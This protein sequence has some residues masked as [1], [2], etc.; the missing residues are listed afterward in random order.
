[1]AGFLGFS[2]IVFAQDNQPNPASNKGTQTMCPVMNEPIDKDLYVDYDGKRIYVCCYGCLDTVKADPAKYVKQLE[3]E[4]VVL[5]KV[6]G[7]NTKNQPELPA[8][9]SAQDNSAAHQH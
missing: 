6:P 3:S 7:D 8:T 9:S 4:G 2:A 1:M 5:E